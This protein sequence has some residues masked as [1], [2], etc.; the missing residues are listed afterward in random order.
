[1]VAFWV[2]TVVGLT[3]VETKG[4]EIWGSKNELR[5]AGKQENT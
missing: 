3:D 4:G 1:M 2:V 5:K